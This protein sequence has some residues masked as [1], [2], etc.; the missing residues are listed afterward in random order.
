MHRL[1]AQTTGVTPSAPN[2]ASHA[3]VVTP[4]PLDKGK[5]APSSSSATGGARVSEEEMRC[6]LRR[7]DR[8]FVSDPPRWG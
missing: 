6:R 7:T 2:R 8:S 3:S 1:E 4:R 5:G